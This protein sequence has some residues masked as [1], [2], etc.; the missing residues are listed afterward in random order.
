MNLIARGLA[1]DHASHIVG[2]EN[3]QLFTEADYEDYS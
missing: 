1:A 2:A 3:D